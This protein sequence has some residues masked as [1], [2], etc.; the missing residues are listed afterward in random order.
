MLVEFFCCYSCYCVV[1]YQSS[2][3]PPFQTLRTQ[4]EAAVPSLH[5]MWLEFSAFLLRPDHKQEFVAEFQAMFNA[6]ED[7]L[8]SDEEVQAELHKRAE[9]LKDK[10]LDIC[11]AKQTEATVSFTQLKRR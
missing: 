4:C 6:F 9:E 1:R 7:D 8:R 11:A 10:L 3:R 2:L 5:Q